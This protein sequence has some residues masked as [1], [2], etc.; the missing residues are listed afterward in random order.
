MTK[1]IIVGVGG[2]SCSGKTTAAKTLHSLFKGSLL[3]HEDD[4][5]FSDTQIP[6]DEAKGEQ[7]WDCP[8]ALNF[9]QFLQ[10][11]AEIRQNGELLEEIASLEPDVKLLVSASEVAEI[12][13]RIQQAFP[14]HKYKF[15]FVDG[16]MLYHDPV[17]VNSLDIRLFLHASYATLKQRREGREAYI[18]KEGTWQDPPGYFDK[19]V[20]PAYEKSHKHLFVNNDTA[21]R[22]TEEAKSGLSIKDCATDKVGLFQIITWAVT[23]ILG[24]LE[25]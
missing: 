12:S 19:M 22:L 24:S 8:E 25:K 3:I 2:P 14:P 10:A 1:V 23:E 21:G 5:Y 6:F 11:L 13:A 17:I 4:F 20:W 9:T 18:T 16:F 7:D 15:V